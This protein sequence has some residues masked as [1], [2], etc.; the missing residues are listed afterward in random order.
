MTD[1]VLFPKWTFLTWLFFVPVGLVVAGGLLIG[2]TDLGDLPFDNLDLWWLVGAVPLGSLIAIYGIARRRRALARFSS[3]ALSPLLASSFSAWRVSVRTGIFL[4]AVVMLIV[5]ALGP[6][7]GIYLEKQE[8]HG[9]DIVA[10]VDVSKSMLARDV[11]PNRLERAKE[12]I[13]QQL[14]ERSVFQGAHRLA[15]SVFAGSSVTRLPLTTDHLAFR[16]KLKEVYIGGVKRGG[17][18]LGRAIREASDLFERSSD[19][20]TKIILLFTDGEDHQQMGEAA[21][22]DAY[23]EQGVRVFTIGVGDPMSTTG[24]QVPESARG[25]AKPMLHD[26]QIVFSRLN[27]EDLRRI[28]EAGNGR[29]VPLN[30]LNR[31]VDAIGDMR[32]SELTTEERMRHKPRYQWFLVAALILLGFEMIIGQRRAVVD[33][34]MTRVW[35]PGN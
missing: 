11:R 27:T 18:D 32:Q 35:E 25:S 5:A 7:W 1:R 34:K 10:I 21:A 30:Q 3:D 24:A 31:V 22:R 17:T 26:G 13:R 16:D 15:L 33:D 29:Y 19:Q 8:V 14:T 20:A 12:E 23:M 4:S 2:L 9:V 28:A 6:R